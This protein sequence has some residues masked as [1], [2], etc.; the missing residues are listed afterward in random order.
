MGWKEE[1][2]DEW[3]GLDGRSPVHPFIR[4]SLIRSLVVVVVVI[5]TPP[6]ALTHKYRIMTDA[7]LIGPLAEAA[8]AAVALVAVYAARPARGL[9]TGCQWRRG[10][11]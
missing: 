7:G 4:H 6:P 5:P 11:D 8:S 9:A 10:S 1:E 3:T 2:E